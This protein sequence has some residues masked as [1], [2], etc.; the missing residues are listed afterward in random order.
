MKASNPLL[1]A[2]QRENKII[3]ST[4]IIY[5]YTG[6]RLKTQTFGIYSGVYKFLN[7]I[8]FVV[9]SQIIPRKTFVYNTVLKPKILQIL[10]NEPAISRRMNVSAHRCRSKKFLPLKISC[11]K[12]RTNRIYHLKIIARAISR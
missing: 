2:G 1:T 12:E 10:T 4:M 9:C 8:D 3:G 7:Y 5:K 6:F 11:E